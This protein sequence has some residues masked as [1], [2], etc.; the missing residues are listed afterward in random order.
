MANRVATFLA[1]FEEEGVVGN[2]RRVRRVETVGA[3]RVLTVFSPDPSQYLAEM[4]QSFID[5]T[6]A[7]VNAR[8]SRVNERDSTVRIDINHAGGRGIVLSGG[9]E[10]LRGAPMA[11]LR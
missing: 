7:L 4:R 9:T 1:R 2:S 5:E 3:T 11:G 10:S 6:G 8:I